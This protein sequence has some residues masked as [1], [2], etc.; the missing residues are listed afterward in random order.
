MEHP[1]IRYLMAAVVQEQDVDLA[2]RALSVLDAPVIHLASTGG[3]LGRRN[4]TLL[5]GLPEG[6]AEKAVEAL[7]RSCR[8]R[9]EYL[10]IP[11][12]GS[13]LP[14]PTPVPVTVGG[15]TAFVIPLER[16]EEF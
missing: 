11:L 6:M 1:P 3:F 12:E 9:V 8:Q 10:A 14:L 4:A 7:Q 16:F 5:I 15:A 2:T 13:P